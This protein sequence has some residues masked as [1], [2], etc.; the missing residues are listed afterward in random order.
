MR[1]KPSISFITVC[2][3]LF[4]FLSV[5]LRHVIQ[6]YF[7]TGD[8]FSILVSSTPH[9]GDVAFFEWFSSGYSSYFNPYP[10]FV[11]PYTNFIRPITNLLWT[12]CIRSG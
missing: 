11:V 8:F 6:D 12:S 3:L 1:T 10:E 2:L 9:S 7:P 4:A 5:A